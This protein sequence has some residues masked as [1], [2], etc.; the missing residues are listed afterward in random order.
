MPAG[1]AA[2][3]ATLDAAAAAAGAGLV[4]AG[5]AAVVAAVAQ[6]EWQRRRVCARLQRLE[7]EIKEDSVTRGDDACLY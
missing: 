1:A 3:A 6:H 2:A 4:A 5:F 7:H